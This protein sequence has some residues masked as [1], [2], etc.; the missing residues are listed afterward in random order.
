MKRTFLFFLF[1]F[2]IPESKAGPNDLTVDQHLSKLKKSGYGDPVDMDEYGSVITFIRDIVK[3]MQLA[4][5]DP[6]H[7]GGKNKS[8]KNIRIMNTPL[9]NALVGPVQSKTEEDNPF[10][11][12]ITTGLIQEIFSGVDFKNKSQIEQGVHRLVGILA[13]ELAHQSAA[14]KHSDER[15]Q[16]EEA[17]ADVIALDFIRYGKFPRSIMP[18]SMKFLSQVGEKESRTKTR[19][20]DINNYFSSHPAGEVRAALVRQAATLDAFKRGQYAVEP[21]KEPSPEVLADIQA[22]IQPSS[23]ETVVKKKGEASDIFDYSLTNLENSL[24]LCQK[25][26]LYG[27]QKISEHPC[28]RVL[29]HLDIVTY[30]LKEY[31]KNKTL[32]DQQKKEFLRIAAQV[33]RIIPDYRESKSLEFQNYRLQRDHC[34]LNL[35]NFERGLLLDSV[36]TFSEGEFLS[37]LE[38]QPQLTVPFRS[39]ANRNVLIREFLPPKHRPK[40]LSKHLNLSGMAIGSFLFEY[41][42]DRT[43]STNGSIYTDLIEELKPHLNQLNPWSTPMALSDYFKKDKNNYLKDLFLLDMNE[44]VFEELKKNPTHPLKELAHYIWNH[45]GFFAFFEMNSQIDDFLS[46]DL[47]IRWDRVIE[48]LGLDQKQAIHEI[49]TEFLKEVETAKNKYPESPLESKEDNPRLYKNLYSLNKQQDYVSR[50]I[51]SKP[52]Y[53]DGKLVAQEMLKLFPIDKS[54]MSTSTSVIS[55]LD[56]A[57]EDLF[58]KFET[59]YQTQLEKDRLSSKDFSNS[60]FN[61][62]KKFI[63]NTGLIGSSVGY[64]IEGPG[65]TEWTRPAQFVNPQSS[66]IPFQKR[67]MEWVDHQNWEDKIKKDVFKEFIKAAQA[68]FENRSYLSNFFPQIS[69]IWNKYH[70]FSTPSEYFQFLWDLRSKSGDTYNKKSLNLFLSFIDAELASLFQEKIKNAGTSKEILEEYRQIQSTMSGETR[71]CANDALKQSL[72]VIVSPLLKEISSTTT[73]EFIKNHKLITACGSSKDTDLYLTEY[74]KFFR[75][76]PDSGN[77]EF[78]YD[79]VDLMSN[80]S[81]VFQEKDDK[82]VFW[83]DSSK[84]EV[85]LAKMHIDPRRVSESEI[86]RT[87]PEKSFGKDQLLEEYA[88]KKPVNDLTA[89]RKEIQARKTS[90]EDIGLHHPKTISVIADFGADLPAFAKGDIIRYSMNPTRENYEK[91]KKWDEVIDKRIHEHQKIGLYSSKDNKKSSG[92]EENNYLYNLPRVTTS[93]EK[94]PIYEFLLASRSPDHPNALVQKKEDLKNLLFDL[95][96]YSK[97]SIQIRL[98][99]AYLNSVPEYERASSLA[100]LLSQ[101]K[102][103]KGGLKSIFEIFSTVGVKTGQLAAIWKIFEDPLA[104]ED[105]A[106]LKDQ[107]KPLDKYDIVKILK[108]QMSPEQYDQIGSVDRILGSASIKTVVELTMK[109]QKKV[110][111]FLRRPYAIDLVKENLVRARNFINEI[112]KDPEFL[113]KSISIKSI[114]DIVEQELEEEIHFENEVKNTEEAGRIFGNSTQPKFIAATHPITSEEFYWKIMVPQPLPGAK[115]IRSEKNPDVQPELLFMEL[116]DGVPF[117]KVLDPENKKQAGKLIVSHSLQALFQD[118]FFNADPHQGNFLIDER[119]HIIYPIDFGQVERMSKTTGIK[120]VFNPDDRYHLATFLMALNSKK[121]DQ[122]RESG[123]FLTSVSHPTSVQKEK[124]KYLINQALQSGQQSALVKIIS[125]FNES[126]LPLSKKFFGILKGLAILQKEE[127]VSPSEF[128]STLKK[129][130]GKVLL[131]K[132]GR[133]ISDATKCLFPNQKQ[134]FSWD[135]NELI[136]GYLGKSNGPKCESANP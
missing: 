120:N 42:D 84:G 13:H 124:F 18:E 102:G 82:T 86:D 34:N 43:I 114:L 76:K 71:Y 20:D 107:A 44:E 65:Q 24:Q 130:I 47:R 113:D 69:K 85:L 8:I 135:P 22:L 45:K 46:T 41:P 117:N 78:F 48:I 98:L 57:Q 50:H 51:P 66:E 87:F 1:L 31:E 52:L 29:S 119:N 21:L 104:I 88:W 112:K 125:S 129:E 90:V 118:C 33:L 11:I 123:L 116:A 54:R 95:L 74:L 16:R 105:L 122:I 32:Q 96:G 27:D 35:S 7:S 26:P 101:R 3:R 80:P 37:L 53:W 132:A 6:I 115:V 127:Y 14:F 75:S 103:E 62:W 136:D 64:N 92:I 106:Q 77:K 15:G 67:F 68:S 111:V 109:D 4:F 36:E 49:Q 39:G 73:K 81:S 23:Q 93:L 25:T 72:K 59:E 55:N 38:P 58:H 89:L 9:K 128:S 83:N 60:L 108:E 99:D 28:C 61:L 131:S 70:V 5:S 19:W 2:L 134:S 17:R 91:I 121:T 63:E 133:L 97:N 10:A 30:Q 56:S 79:L 12:F 94:I 100:Y 40:W 110:V 126:G